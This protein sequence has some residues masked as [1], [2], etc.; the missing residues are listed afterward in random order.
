MRNLLWKECREQAWLAAF[1]A[2][3]LAAFA[4]IGL[5]ARMVADDVM[6]DWA[7]GL[8]VGLL[9]VLAATAGVPAERAAGS[10]P[11]LVALP[12]RPGRVVIAKGAVGL[13]VCLLPIAAAALVTVIIAGGR[14]VY[15]TDL[16]AT[17]AR[18]ALSAAALFVW[19]AALTVR[20]PTE[21]RAALIAVGVGVLWLLAT[22][23][24]TIPPV[25]GLASAVSPLAFVVTLN[26]D[27]DGF[28]RL[29]T[30]VA[31]QLVV[32]AGVT[33]AGVRLF[34]RGDAAA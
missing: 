15:T 21:S 25:R 14:E 1:A 30:I 11:S 22:A 3:V 13:L 33:W 17:Y 32:L 28:P 26:A 18:A 20:L 4:A 7:A 10:L 8:A 2:V 19:M 16:L 27:L 12:V 23:G 9:P 24:L 6:V 29:P 34:G 5:R 31:V